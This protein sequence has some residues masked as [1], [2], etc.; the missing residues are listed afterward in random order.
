MRYVRNSHHKK[1]DGFLGVKT[2]YVAKDGL[3]PDGNGGYKIRA[4]LINIQEANKQRDFVAVAYVN[5]NGTYVYANDESANRSIDYVAK[6]ALADTSVNSTGSY[7]NAVTSYYVKGDVGADGK[8][9]LTY[10]E[11]AATVYSKYSDAQLT[12]IRYCVAE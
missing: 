6:M 9:E 3:I 7:T 1:M 11:N 2:H 10:Q 4:A 8:Y 5:I 12:V